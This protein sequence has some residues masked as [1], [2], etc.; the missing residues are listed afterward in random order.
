MH[1]EENE[2][3]SIGLVRAG[4][5]ALLFTIGIG[6]AALLIRTAGGLASLFKR[7][8]KV[9]LKVKFKPKNNEE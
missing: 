5:G 6:L 8:E 4:G 1:Q 9:R 3:R 2:N 7:T